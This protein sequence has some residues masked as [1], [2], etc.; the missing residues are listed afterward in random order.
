MFILFIII[1]FSL[2]CTDERRRQSQAGSNEAP[3]PG[4]AA[5]FMVDQASGLITVTADASSD[6]VYSFCQVR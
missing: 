5:G 2:L 1:L 3:G 4:D 6:E